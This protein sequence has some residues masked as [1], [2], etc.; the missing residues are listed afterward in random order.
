M[1]NQEAIEYLNSI[2]VTTGI[3]R[4]RDELVEEA[5]D[6]AIKAL[7]EERLKM[8]WNIRINDTVK[9]LYWKNNEV[10]DFTITDILLEKYV[11]G[12]KTIIRAKY[13]SENAEC[14][15]LESFFANDFI[16][17]MNDAEERCVKE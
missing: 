15:F 8:V 9:I 5:I 10:M 4:F 17:A 1:T 16:K 14:W 6:M 11:G 12:Y 13:Y 3:S 2:C 7:K